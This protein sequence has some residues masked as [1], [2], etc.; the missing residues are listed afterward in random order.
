VSRIFAGPRRY[1]QGPGVLGRLGE[2]LAPYGPGPLVV[3]DAV[4]LELFGDRVRDS[5]A[6]LDPVVRLLDGEITYDRVRSIVDSLG[7]RDPAVVVGL[8]GGK[9]LDAGKAVALALGLPVVTVPTAASNDS[10]ASAAVAMYDESHQ[11]VAVDRLPAHPDLV[12][13]DTAVIARAPVALL[14]GGIGD[15]VAKKFEAEGC[16]DGTGATPVG[17]RPLLTGVAIASACYGALR[18]HAVGG[19]AAA[20]RGEPDADLE[21]LVEAVVLMSGLGF[22]NGG[23]SLAH[24][25]TRGLMRARGAG[26]ALHGLQV[27]W[28]TLVQLAYEGRPELAEVTA[29]N[30]ETGLPVS[31]AEL[32][33]ASATDAEIAEIVR[34]TMTAPHLPNLAVP[35]D[36]AD[37]ASTIRRVERSRGGRVCRT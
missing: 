35:V 25:L 3:A 8:G 22:E 17:G 16:R 34:L 6:G 9:S 15:A 24:S 5:L 37:L 28:A 10:P 30:R 27:A 26:A 19:L 12:L 14:R 11:M 18:R 13:V 2:L 33:M 23:L 4:V 29:F 7:G 20:R 32:G 1:V 36:A 31:L 21:A